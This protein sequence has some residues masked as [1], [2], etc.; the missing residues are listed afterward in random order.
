M[1][2]KGFVITL[3]LVV[4]CCVITTPYCA[5]GYPLRMIT[6]ALSCAVELHESTRLICLLGG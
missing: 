3:G 4:C 5:R 2:S 1:P 6:A